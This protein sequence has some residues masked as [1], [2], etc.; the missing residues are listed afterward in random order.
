MATRIGFNLSIYCVN[1][2]G[3]LLRIVIMNANCTIASPV[4][5][6]IAKRATARHIP[7]SG[8]SV[9]SL[10]VFISSPARRFKLLTTAASA[11]PNADT[12][13]A[14]RDQQFAQLL[15]AAS[16]GDAQAFERF[17]QCTVNYA[18]LIACR[19]AGNNH[20]DDVLSD[21]YFQAWRDASRFDATRG[22]ALS[23][24]LVIVRSRALDRLRAE[25]HRHGG[26]DGAPDVDSATIEE[27]DV[28]GPETL[29]ESVQTASQL[30]QAMLRLSASERW[31]LALAYFRDHT[32]SEISAMTGLPL[33]TVKSLLT[34]S[35]QKLREMLT[36][37]QDAP[38][39]RPSPQLSMP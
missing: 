8:G 33:G 39:T 21:A 23:W 26:L 19:V 29:L 31:V 15:S 16:K 27:M 7:D 2:N 38:D 10:S 11:Q 9:L 36:S 28:P 4:L 6:F 34:R 24:L 30:H 1:P 12:V 3:L 14:L 37:G 25:N 13:N 35:Q 17:Y 5:N 18:H 22:N 20:C 32:Q